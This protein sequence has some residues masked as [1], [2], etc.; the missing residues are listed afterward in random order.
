MPVVIESSV[1]V[2]PARR[3]LAD[4]VVREALGPLAGHVE[5]VRFRIPAEP[6]RRKKTRCE[7]HVRLKSAAELACRGAADNMADAL[8]NA[9]HA[10]RRKIFTELGLPLP[11]RGAPSPGPASAERRR[12]R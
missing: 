7:L 2:S 1:P 10:M 4:L 5:S 9:A 6:A 11:P 12:T 3:L 8:E